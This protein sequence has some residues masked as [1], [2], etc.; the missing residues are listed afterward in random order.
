MT[1]SGFTPGEVLK[2][3]P[4]NYATV[5]VSSNGTFSISDEGLLSCPPVLV[6]A[7]AYQAPLYT[8]ETGSWVAVSNSVYGPI[9]PC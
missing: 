1:G 8:F 6:T 9:G 3:Q 5:T 4:W 7:Y 2:I